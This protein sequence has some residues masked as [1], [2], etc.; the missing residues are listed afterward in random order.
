MSPAKFLSSSSLQNSARACALH[1]LGEFCGPRWTIA[2]GASPAQGSWRHSMPNSQ[3]KSRG[4]D[5]GS[6][7]GA[8]SCAPDLMSSSDSLGGEEEQRPW[9]FLFISRFRASPK[10]P[11]RRWRGHWACF[12][13][14]A[15]SCGCVVA[16][17]LLCL[18]HLLRTDLAS[19]RQGMR[20]RLWTRCDYL[21]TDG[22][23]P[24][25]DVRVST[26]P[27]VCPRASP[28]VVRLYSK[29]YTC[30]CVIHTCRWRLQ[31]SGLCGAGT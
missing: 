16:S 4:G 30:R 7:D 15:G 9:P 10:Q 12:A 26:V 19:A 14:C 29:L 23:M 1:V 27:V 17:M 11:R 31:D 28:P 25:L 24:V 20:R 22:Y 21:R 8:V 2:P 5:V 13:G 6:T 18:S 3:P